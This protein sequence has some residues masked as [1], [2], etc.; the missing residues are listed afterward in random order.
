MRKAIVFILVAMFVMGALALV[1]CKKKV[2]PTAAT[3]STALI[4]T[5][6]P[7]AVPTAIGTAAPTA[8]TAEMPTAEKKPEGK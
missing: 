8:K 1:G 3:A 7:T 5:A 4:P 6:V 2:E